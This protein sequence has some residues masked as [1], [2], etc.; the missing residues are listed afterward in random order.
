MK[1]KENCEQFAYELLFFVIICDFGPSPTP[2]P[3]SMSKFPSGGKQYRN[4]YL[5][6]DCLRCLGILEDCCWD[7]WGPKWSPPAKSPA[8]MSKF[9]SGAKNKEKTSFYF[10]SDFYE[11]K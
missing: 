11:K 3:A 10:F 8:S 7:L 2:S 6:N 1:K 4:K 9:P 5:F